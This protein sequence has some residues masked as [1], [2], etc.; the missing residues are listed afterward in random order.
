M[1][2]AR[3]LLTGIV[4]LEVMSRGRVE[5]VRSDIGSS[6]VGGVVGELGRDHGWQTSSSV[7]TR[8]ET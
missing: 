8:E 1:E 5:D 7:R 3:Q 6:V 2:V 4:L